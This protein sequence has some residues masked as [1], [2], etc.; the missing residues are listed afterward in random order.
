MLSVENHKKSQ[1]SSD[2]NNFMKKAH[3]LFEIV[4]MR[5]C[6]SILK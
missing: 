6:L 5:A 1:L 3:T 4:P 2:T